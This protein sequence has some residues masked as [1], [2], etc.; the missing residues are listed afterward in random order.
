MQLIKAFFKNDLFR[1]CF[2]FIVVVGTLC[3]IVL[4]FKNEGITA[5][6]ENALI[7]NLQIFLL[8]IGAVSFYWQSQKHNE[9]QPVLRLLALGCL[10]AVCRELDEA[11]A[12][13]LPHFHWKFGFLFSVVMLIYAYAH[14]KMAW[15]VLSSVA[16][17]PVF[18]LFGFLIVVLLPFSEF[19][20]CGGLTS[21]LRSNE[22]LNIVCEEFVEVVCYLLVFLLSL[23]MHFSRRK[24]LDKFYMKYGR[25]VDFKTLSKKDDKIVYKINTE[26]GEYVLIIIPSVTVTRFYKYMCSQGLQQQLYKDGMDAAEI[27][28]AYMERNSIVSVHRCFKGTDN[29][30]D[31]KEMLRVSGKVYGKLH[32]ITMAPKYKKRFMLLSYPNVFVRLYMYVGYVLYR[33]ISQYFK[34]Y[35]LRNMPWGICHRDN[36]GRNILFDEDGNTIL[37]DFDKHRYMSLVEGLIYFYKRHLKDKSLFHVFLEAYEKE[38][39]L[40]KEEKE[41]LEKKLKIMA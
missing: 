26:K 10:L 37:L 8:L 31:D 14:R 22:Q 35:K 20:E 25:Q 38:R 12:E 1:L 16:R 34:Y 2:Y 27:V 3:G 23:E 11:F 7:E 33:R 13:V 18:L 30:K 6:Y 17:F 21:Y 40:T 24:I 32:R 19:I 5:F 29:F 4:L 28:D 9:L 15:H 36:N 39:P 41:Y